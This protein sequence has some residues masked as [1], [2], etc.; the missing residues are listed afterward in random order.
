MPALRN[1]VRCDAVCPCKRRPVI[2]CLPVWAVCSLLHARAGFVLRG[3]VCAQLAVSRA[4]GDHQFKDSRL[5]Q[6]E[7][8]VQWLLLLLLP[9]STHVAA[10]NCMCAAPG[11]IFCLAPWC[12]ATRHCSTLTCRC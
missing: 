11:T 2:P 8:M 7:Q 5:P 3:R 10:T 4:L 6:A 1:V 12:R 9:A